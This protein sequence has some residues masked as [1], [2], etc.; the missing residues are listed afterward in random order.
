MSVR[1][2][3]ISATAYRSV[4]PGTIVGGNA[5]LGDVIIPGIVGVVSFVGTALVATLGA[6]LA[7]SLAP[8]LAAPALERLVTLTEEEIGAPP[9]A[10]LGFV[11]EIVLG[12]RA[13]FIGFCLFAPVLAIL[14]LSE[15]IFPV[16]VVATVPIRFAV[17]ALW[18]AYTMFDY[19]Q[20]LRG[21][22]I[23]ARLRLLRRAL[24][25]TIGYGV[26]C[27]LL[28]WTACAIPLLL[29]VGVIAAT[30]LFWRVAQA[31]PEPEEEPDPDVIPTEPDGWL[32]HYVKGFFSLGVVGFMKVFFAMS[33]WHWWN[34]RTSGVLNGGGRRPGTTGRG[35][36]ENISWA[37]VMI[38]FVV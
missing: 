8:T 31:D 1:P 19:P 9:R 7:L 37:V 23:R 11:R 38:V 32:E 13:S 22:P 20:S 33:P 26:T 5:P 25:P 34:L 36:V 2:N 17:A 27:S 24:A 30:Q 35:R 6:L 21:V 28:F 15:L 29:P 16:S 18:L 12:L 4:R 3:P 14:F 10:P